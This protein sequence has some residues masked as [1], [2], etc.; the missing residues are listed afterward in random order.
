MSANNRVTP[1]GTVT[2]QRFDNSYCQGE[3]VHRD[4]VNVTWRGGIG[5]SSNFTA[6]G[7]VSY[8]A[9]YHGVNILDHWTDSGCEKLAISSVGLEI[10]DQ[11]NNTDV[12][13]GTVG[14]NGTVRAFAII[15]DDLRSAGGT[16]YYQLFRDNNCDETT[17]DS[18]WDKIVE[19]GTSPTTPQPSDAF[20]FTSPETISYKATY[21]GPAGSIDSH[22]KFVTSISQ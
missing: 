15:S 8:L 4:V 14:P 22:C 6:H 16:V 2:Y 5:Y 19:V 21:D 11:S 18:S 10:I 13:N 20:S 7:D 12:T 1:Y 9:I 17:H 3:P